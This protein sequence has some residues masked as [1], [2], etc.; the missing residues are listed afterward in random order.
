MN[1]LIIQENGRNKENF[2]MRECHSLQYWL[3]ELGVNAKC[4]GKGHE[5]Y[6]VALKEISKDYDV[7]FCLENYNS[8]WLPS[9]KEFKQK[10][11]FWSI[12]SHCNL[13][14][15][16]DFCLDSKINI[17]LNSTA[18][19][20]KHFE[21]IAE[22]CIWFPNAVDT[23]WFKPLE[24]KKDIDIGFV[25]SMIAD[26]PKLIPFL[27]AIIQLESFSNVLGKEMIST[28]NKFKVGFNKS[29]S[30]DIN[31][32]IFETTACMVPIVT[33]NVP[34]LNKLYKLDEEIV[35]YSNIKEMIG[36]CVWLL[37][38]DRARM[39]IARNGYERT[40]KY[41]TYKERVANLM[42]FIK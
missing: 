38:D 3:T 21:N 6:S 25:G 39:Q 9:L 11:I 41:H 29:I 13:K 20:I 40:I 23:R 8:G 2:H 7:I 19:Y 5:N 4:W 31:Y 34:D 33:N 30:D 15:H 24:I 1:I 18:S 17:H 22:K 35:V 27:K 36:T 14:E 16:V 10:K 26:R 28:L 32:R 37:K 12:D 42:D